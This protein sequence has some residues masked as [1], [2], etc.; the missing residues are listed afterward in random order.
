MDNET[1]VAAGLMN[2]KPTEALSNALKTPLELEHAGYT[3]RDQEMAGDGTPMESRER[4]ASDEAAER[5]SFARELSL[6]VAMPNV[7]PTTGWVRRVAEAMNC[8]DPE[9]G[10]RMLAQL[11][12]EVARGAALH[13]VDLMSD[14][15]PPPPMQMT[16]A[17]DVSDE[18]LK[19][20]QQAAGPAVKMVRKEPPSP[21]PAPQP[22]PTTGSRSDLFA[23]AAA[24]NVIALLMRQGMMKS[25]VDMLANQDDPH[26][27][28]RAAVLNALS[29]FPGLLEKMGSTAP[30]P[31]QRP[32]S[33]DE[34]ARP[35]ADYIANV[36]GKP[37]AFRKFGRHLKSVSIHEGYMQLEGG[38]TFVATFVV[39]KP[40]D[41]GA[42]ADENVMQRLRA[43]VDKTIANTVATLS[44]AS[45]RQHERDTADRL[46]RGFC[47]NDNEALVTRQTGPTAV[48]RE[49]FCPRCGFVD[50]R[51]E[52]YWNDMYDPVKMVEAANAVTT[53]V[54]QQ[55]A[56]AQQDR[57]M[58]PHTDSGP[59]SAKQKPLSQLASQPYDER[60]PF[61]DIS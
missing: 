15:Q 6:A 20:M 46:G 7:V 25:P 8:D 51:G 54:V 32:K 17:E 23:R 47:P 1:R 10:D 28:A 12:I 40:G 14:K 3:T 5:F 24:K 22:M 50:A 49:Q 44:P 9:S 55:Q 30:K 52:K 36:S 61:K 60:D 27:I 35:L 2:Q 26:Q 37:V 39:A 57:D 38:D 21:A 11:L 4:A 31:D 19:Q 41:P 16:V 29:L 53:S 48:T 56:Q 42:P 13:A 34:A 58:F 18:R 59:A 45:F 43:N 33:I